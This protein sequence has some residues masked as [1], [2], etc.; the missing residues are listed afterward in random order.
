[1]TL[2]SRTSTVLGLPLCRG[3]FTPQL[4]CF[5]TLSAASVK[6]D[7]GL[8]APLAGT[9]PKRHL[10]LRFSGLGCRDAY[11]Q[12]FCTRRTLQCHSCGGHSSFSTRLFKNASF[13]GRGSASTWCGICC[14]SVGNTCN[15]SGFTKSAPLP[16]NNSRVLLLQI[17][18]CCC[19]DMH[20]PS[21]SYRLPTLPSF[22]ETL[23]V[24]V[25]LCSISYNCVLPHDLLDSRSAGGVGHRSP[26]GKVPESSGQTHPKVS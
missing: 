19:E 21:Q 26:H 24:C 14:L 16:G 18:P 3:S 4:S 12:R 20:V 6:S 17:C 23:R 10:F 15:N 22:P 25:A 1:M 13:A 11:M 5:V 8:S 2:E 7:L 9:H